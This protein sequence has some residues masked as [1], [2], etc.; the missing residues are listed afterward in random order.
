MT[1]HESQ[2][3]A[4]RPKREAR[5]PLASRKCRGG[6]VMIIILA[7]LT[8]VSILSV[9]LLQITA[10]EHRWARDNVH[11]QQAFWL[12]ESA[13]QRAGSQLAA[14]NEYSG[15]TWRIGTDQLGGKHAAMVTI[16][17]KP[18]EGKPNRRLVLV[19]ADYPDHP[20]HRVR[21]TKQTTVDL[22]VLKRL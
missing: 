4:F 12:A 20:T 8:I 7:C 2:Q 21:R 19:Q 5:V 6:M 15:E 18:V 11:T 16:T 3:G 17:V 10:S 22:L 14:D 13:L 1:G 9:S